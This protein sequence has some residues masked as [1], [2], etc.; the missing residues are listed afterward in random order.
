MGSAYWGLASGRATT[1][2]AG[3]W[4]G[5]WHFEGVEFGRGFVQYI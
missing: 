5:G 2:Q 3:Y 1:Q 4:L